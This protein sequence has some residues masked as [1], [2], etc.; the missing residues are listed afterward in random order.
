MSLCDECRVMTTRSASWSEAST[1]LP[2]FCRHQIIETVSSSEK[3]TLMRKT[4]SI[5]MEK[6]S[7]KN[8]LLP[9]AETDQMVIKNAIIPIK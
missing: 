3:A 7:T 4:H 1:K 2:H 6:W 9:S 8:D 5:A